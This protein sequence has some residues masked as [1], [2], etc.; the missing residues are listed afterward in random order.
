MRGV[1]EWFEINVSDN[2]ECTNPYLRRERQLEY[3]MESLKRPK[4]SLKRRLELPHALT[5]HA[6]PNFTSAI[7]SCSSTASF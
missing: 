1:W 4:A 2:R 5:L 6:V 3:A 7:L